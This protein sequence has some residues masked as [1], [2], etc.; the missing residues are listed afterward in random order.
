MS[1]GT[2]KVLATGGAKNAATKSAYDL[3]YSE[4]DAVGIGALV[5]DLKTFIEEGI[6]GPE[7]TLRLRGTEAY[8]KRF[9]ANAQRVAKGLRALGEAEYV[10]KE[11]FYQDV[12][13]RYGLPE[14]YYSRG[15]L[16][17]QE[18]FEKL[19]A[20]DI[21]DTELED[22]ISIA[23]KRVMNANPE[24]TQALK[25]FYPD[26]TNA[27]ILAYTLDPKNAIENIKRKVTAAEIGGAQLGAGL[28][29]TAAGAEALGAA[30]VTGQGYQKEAASIAEATMRGGQLS[31]IYKQDPYTQQTAEALLL[32]VPGSAEALKKTK[33]L[34]SL[35]IA[36]FSGR[37]GMGAIAR[38]R[39]GGL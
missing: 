11:D 38:D 16:G 3:L 6:S 37:A 31:S 36:S 27:D 17:R 19:L 18:G 1:N 9:A 7:F 21:S 25:Q 39:A 23:Q 29:A 20:N 12:M 34:E 24:V 33:K 4:F 14:S 10:A 13:R 26:I 35:E 15:E 30:G 22:R 32:N 8:K 28:Q 2:T 5:P